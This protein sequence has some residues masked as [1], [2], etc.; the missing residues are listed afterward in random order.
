MTAEPQWELVVLEGRKEVY[1]WP[2]P[3]AEQALTHLWIQRPFGWVWAISRQEVRQYIVHA[4][5]MDCLELD[6]MENRPFVEL[7]SLL[8]E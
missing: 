2:T 4:W 5:T 1:L 6:L 3:A 7:Y 8:I